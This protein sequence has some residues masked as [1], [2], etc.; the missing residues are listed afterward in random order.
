[1]SPN[2]NSYA[3]SWVGTIKHECLNHFIVFGERHLRYLISEYVA[4][5]NTTRPHSSMGNMPL[6]LSLT[7][8]TGEIKCRTKLG[9]IIKNYYRE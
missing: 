9:G 5:Y 2:M 7:K 8:N 3:E 1:M 6:E 4:H